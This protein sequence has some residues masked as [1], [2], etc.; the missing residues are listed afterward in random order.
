MNEILDL[1]NNMFQNGNV[2]ILQKYI[3][4]ACTTKL[5]DRTITL[6]NHG[7]NGC[8]L[9]LNQVIIV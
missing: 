4:K 1:D 6:E 5:V 2:F 7:Q 9:K 3:N 8:V